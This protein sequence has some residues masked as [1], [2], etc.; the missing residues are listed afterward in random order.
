M[1][2]YKIIAI[3]AATTLLAGCVSV[4]DPNNYRP[5]TE[6]L[7]QDYYACDSGSTGTA[8]STR[9]NQYGGSSYVGPHINSDLLLR[10]MEAHNYRLRRATTGEWVVGVA[11]LPLT[12]PLVILT[13]GMYPGDAV[14]I[15][16]GSA[17]PDANASDSAV[18]TGN[19]TIEQ[20][21]SPVAAPP[22]S[23]STTAA[24]APVVASTT[25]SVA[26]APPVSVNT[27]QGAVAAPP[28]SITNGQN[29]PAAPPVSAPQPV[30]N[31]N[32]PTNKTPSFENF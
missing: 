22:V 32:A 31:P 13:A 21:E 2:P 1:K 30:V 29:A 15:G 17:D 11:F 8:A 20:S 16:G 5:Q 25:P 26:A 12:V 23:A 9:W 19:T 4:T 24:V 14:R 28:I 6:T 27:N 10:C 3:T 18:A 7:S